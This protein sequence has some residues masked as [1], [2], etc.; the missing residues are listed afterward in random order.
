MILLNSSDNDTLD[1][2]NILDLTLKRWLKWLIYL[3]PN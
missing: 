3:L 2:E 1:H